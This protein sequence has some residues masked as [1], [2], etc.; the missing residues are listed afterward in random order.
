MLAIFQNP[1]WIRCALFISIKHRFLHDIAIYLLLFITQKEVPEE[2]LRTPEEMPVRHPYL[3]FYFTIFFMT[4]DILYN[5][6]WPVLAASLTLRLNC[7][8][9]LSLCF[10]LDKIRFLQNNVSSHS[11]TFSPHITLFFLRVQICGS[12]IKHLLSIVNGEL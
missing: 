3:I 8:N 1:Q 4:S 2:P 5:E 9:R 11:H 7:S 10:F 6:N 12:I